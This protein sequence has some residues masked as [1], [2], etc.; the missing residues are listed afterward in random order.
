MINV[1]NVNK[2]DRIAVATSGGRDSICLLHYLWSNKDSLEIDVCALN[3]DHNIRGEESKRDSDFVNSFCSN[4]GIPLYSYSCDAVTFSKENKYSLEQGARILRYRIFDSFLE[5]NPSFKIA[6]AH[7]M[8]DNFETILFNMFRGSSL[9]GLKGIEKNNYKFV[10]PLLSTSRKNIEEYIKV[11]NLPY[12]DD[13][14]NTDTSYSRNYIRNEIYPLIEDK[15]PMALKNVN[16]LAEIVSEEDS[17]LDNLAEEI[18]SEEKDCFLVPI[19][20]HPVLIKRAIVLCLKKLDIIK[21]YERI[22]IEL[23]FNLINQETGT[24]I[25][26]PKSVIAIKQYD[27]IVLMKKE[28]KENQAIPL[29]LDKAIQFGEWIIL[30]SKNNEDSTTKPLYFDIDKVPSNSII[31]TRKDGDIFEKFGGGTKKLSDYFTDKKIPLKERDKIPLLTIGNEILI[32]FGVEI[33]NK[34]KTNEKT[35]TIYYTSL[36]KAD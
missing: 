14:S 20:Q 30:I 10:R 7:H 19:N 31:R 24:T 27:K 2:K 1:L 28:V 17:F 8:E 15:F 18:I 12:V 32:I 33:S 9:K 35:K 4:L 36:K 23:V 21:D 26:L 34:V 29:L 11:N 16:S 6:T 25:D 13:S 3:V 5:N 22:H